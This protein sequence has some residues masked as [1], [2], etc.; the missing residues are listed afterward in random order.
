MARSANIFSNDWCNIVF[1]FK[2]KDYG[3]YIIRKTSDRRHFVSIVIGCLLFSLAV[4]MPTI[5]KNIIPEKKKDLGLDKTILDIINK[6]KEKEKDEPKP[7]LPE[8]IKIVRQQV[9]FVIPKADE[10]IKD[11]DTIKTQ[12]QLIEI[13]TEI[14][15]TTNLKGDTSAYD[16]SLLEQK[17]KLVDDDNQTYDL[18]GV[19]EQPQFP[20]GTEKL[21]E[22]LGGKI[23]YPEYERDNDISGTVYIQFEVAKDGRI[24]DVQVVRSVTKNLDDEAVRVIRGMPSW[25]PGKQ[26]GRAVRVKYVLPVK[27]TVAKR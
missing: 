20:G 3:A 16:P 10:T 4:S 1:E 14:G 13:K 26:N 24:K 11:E 9:Q 21:Y 5:I 22:Y 12:K 23:N 6:Q 25:T 8:E 15:A 18:A 2:N 27:F 19:E 17:S 7:L